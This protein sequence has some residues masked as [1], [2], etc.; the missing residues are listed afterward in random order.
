MA[1]FLMHTI[2]IVSYRVKPRRWKAKKVCMGKN[3]EVREKFVDQPIRLG[4]VE[5]PSSNDQQ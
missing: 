3:K 2:I 1:P 4:I 5:C